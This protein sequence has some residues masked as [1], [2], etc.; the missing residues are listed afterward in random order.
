MNYTI[1]PSL[2]AANFADL[3]EQLTALKQAGIKHLHIDVMDGHFVPAISFGTPFVK[4]LKTQY[5]FFL[6]VHLMVSEPLKQ[7]PQFIDAG[8]DG[9]TLHVE[10][11]SQEEIL[12][13][14]NLIKH[15]DLKAGIS[16]KPATDIEAL[17]P[18][19]EQIDLIL[20][21][22]VEPGAGGQKFMPDALTRAQKIR[23]LFPE[24]ELQIDGG[25]NNDTLKEAALSGA[26]NFVAGTALLKGDI[27][28]NIQRFK[29][30]LAEVK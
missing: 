16:L 27:Q 2:L 21:M 22:S 11:G 17:I 20:L 14:L 7:I 26:T 12:K 29:Q 4:N 23:Q 6:D 13:A 10:A 30:I 28:K 8:A 5:D 15:S 24:V 18:F 3:K 1:S 19:K 25:I 9:L